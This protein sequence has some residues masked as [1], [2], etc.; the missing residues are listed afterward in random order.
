MVCNTFP[1]HELLLLQQDRAIAILFT[2]DLISTDLVLTTAAFALIDTWS[3]FSK[4]LKETISVVITYTSTMGL[5]YF[6]NLT[7]R[8]FKWSFIFWISNTLVSFCV[9]VL[10]GFLSFGYLEDCSN[11]LTELRPSVYLSSALWIL[12]LVCFYWSRLLQGVSYWNG[13]NWMAL[14]GRQINNFDE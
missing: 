3:A 7:L 9:C 1:I 14:R 12:W 11:W 8:V 4:C 13:R 10:E 6:L 2:S 5:K